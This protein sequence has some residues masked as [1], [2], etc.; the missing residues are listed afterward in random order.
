[1]PPAVAAVAAGLGAGWLLTAPYALPWYAALAWPA[2][3]LAPATLLDRAL[4]AQLAVLTVA[5][6]PGRVVG[7]TPAVESVTLGLRRFVAPVLLAALVVAVARWAWRGQPAQ[8]EP[9]S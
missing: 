4:L 2:L 9:G 7:L 6:V 8:R 1:V 3:A 5:Y